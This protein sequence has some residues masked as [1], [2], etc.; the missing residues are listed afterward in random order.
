MIYNAATSIKFP[1]LGIEFNN[2]GSSI[3][4]FGFEIAFYGIVIALGMAAG[5]LVAQWQAKRTGQNPDL[6]LDFALYAIILSVIGARLFYVIF[7]WDE[8]KDDLIQILNIR[9][10]GLAIYGGIIV[11]VLTAWIYTKIKRCPLVYW[12]IRHVLD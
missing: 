2:V 3:E 7:S 11:A 10:G 4:V 1:N 12:W 9:Q 8:F 6:Y 5:Y